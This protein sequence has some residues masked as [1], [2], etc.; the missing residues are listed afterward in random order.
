MM[1]SPSPASR[2]NHLGVKRR[3]QNRL[4]VGSHWKIPMVKPSKYPSP[5]DPAADWRGSCG[6]FTNVIN[7]PTQPHLIPPIW[8]SHL[9]SILMMIPRW[10]T[11]LPET[12]SLE[13]SHEESISMS[14]LIFWEFSVL[15]LYPWSARTRFSCWLRSFYSSCSLLLSHP[16]PTHMLFGLLWFL[17][18][19]P[20][21]A[22]TL[23]IPF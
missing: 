10:L 2:R 22:C 7:L 3:S 6:I 14:I 8:P 4:L 11:T 19:L 5:A 20:A 1:Q 16:Q 12:L 9:T 17:G 21:T 15:S 23:T 18:K 13:S